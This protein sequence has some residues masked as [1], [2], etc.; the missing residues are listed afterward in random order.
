MANLA[1]N[2]LFLDQVGLQALIKKIALIKQELAEGA[3]GIADDVV[4]LT[5]LVNT[6]IIKGDDGS[7]EAQG[8]LADVIASAAALREELG[9]TPADADSTV[10][11]RLVALEDAVKALQDLTSDYEELKA[12]AFADV[13]AT[14]KA[15]DQ[16]VILSYSN[17]AGEEVAT[18]EIST[19]DF[20]VHGLVQD[21]NTVT[22]EGSKVTLPSGEEIDVPADILDHKGDKYLV[23]RFCVAHE[24]TDSEI[25]HDELKTIWVNVNDLFNDYDFEGATDDADYLK[26]EATEVVSGVAGT[27]N[28]VTVKVSLGDAQKAVNDLVE[29]KTVSA[30]DAN[31]NYRGIIALNDDLDAEIAAREASDKAAEELKGKVDK[32]VDEVETETTGLLDRADVAEGKIDDLEDWVNNS[33]IPAAYISDYLDWTIEGST[34]TEPN[35]GSYK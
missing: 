35:I 17:K 3:Q 26:V 18:A 7:T 5:E 16:K 29:G 2:K 1:S 25:A 6:I 31:K 15:G 34:T 13:K 12:K 30:S 27:Q 23:F 28:K 14:Y 21:V 9:E 19:A 4:A 11:D 8:I 10:Y 24:N 22:V 20:I 33:A 32:L